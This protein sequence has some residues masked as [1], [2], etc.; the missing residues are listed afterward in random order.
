MTSAK[1]KPAIVAKVATKK[2]KARKKP[3]PEKVEKLKCDFDFWRVS[4]SLEEVAYKLES[5]KDVVELLAT[6]LTNSPESG[7]AWAVT[8]MLEAY[9]QRLE[10]LSAEMMEGH[11]QYG[12]SA[13]DYFVE[14]K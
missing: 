6:T 12:K 4:N 1:K 14:W 2:A 10:R 7:V 3:A 9:V 5:V 11:R 8:E 13:L